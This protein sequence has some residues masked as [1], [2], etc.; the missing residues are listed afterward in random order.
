MEGFLK[1]CGDGRVN[2]ATINAK[3]RV[4]LNLSD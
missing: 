3:P 4:E 1:K 2:D